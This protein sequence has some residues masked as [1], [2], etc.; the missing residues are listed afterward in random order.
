LIQTDP[1]L[2]GQL[3]DAAEAKDDDEV[4]SLLDT[5]VENDKNAQESRDAV[6]D[7]ALYSQPTDGE[8]NGPCYAVPIEDYQN[9]HLL[10]VLLVNGMDYAGKISLPFCERISW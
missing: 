3:C 1:K 9:Y 2:G 7:C 5:L 6:M 8:G 4:I 10:V